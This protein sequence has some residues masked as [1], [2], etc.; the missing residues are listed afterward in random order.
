MFERYTEK[1]RRVIFFSRYEASEFGSPYI[2]AKFLL[3]GLVRESPQVVTRWLD[4]Q[5]DWPAA[6]RREISQSIE[7]KPHLPTSVDLPISE[8]AKRV[9]V[10]AAEEAQRLAHQH[11]GTEH[12]FLGLLREPESYVGR[13]LH[14]FGVNINTVRETLAKE[15]EQ[16]G[17]VSGLGSGFGSGS[18]GGRH[19]ASLR[20]VQIVIMIEGGSEPLQVQWPA[21]IPAIGE[22]LSL[23]SGIYNVVN[24][25]WKVDREA[26]RPTSLSKVVMY[27]RRLDT[28]NG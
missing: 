21:R 8:D 26:G 27:L 3:L 17:V 18:A 25:E 4:Q 2:E 5:T 10:Y 20:T 7:L 14:G 13:M 22:T 15:G 12:L 11:I 19:A 23:E 24:V 9:L 6:F 28:T 16:Q 1:A